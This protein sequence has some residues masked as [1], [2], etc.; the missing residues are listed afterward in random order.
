MLPF[1]PLLLLRRTYYFIFCMSCLSILVKEFINITVRVLYNFDL[2]LNHT[3]S[4]YIGTVVD[5]V[6]SLCLSIFYFFLFSIFNCLDIE[7]TNHHKIN[8]K[9]I[10][11]LV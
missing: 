6:F 7:V 2:R 5:V 9:G 1:I 11:V 10:Y 3:L 4:L 8:K